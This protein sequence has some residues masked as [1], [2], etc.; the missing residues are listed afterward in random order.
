MSTLLTDLVW[1]WDLSSADATITDQHS[2]L[3]LSRVGTTITES[4]GGPDGGPCINFGA[5]AGKYRNASVAKT[6][7]YDDGFTA[8][9]WV[10]PTGTAFAAN[11][12]L[13]HRVQSGSDRYF[14]MVV[15]QSSLSA[16]R[17]LVTDASQSSRSVDIS[18]QSALN[19]WYMLTLVD[20]GSVLSA[21]RDGVLE[22]TSSTVIGARGTGV[23]DFGIGGSA[24]DATVVSSVNHYGQLAMAGVWNEPLDTA[25]ITALYN[26]GNGRRYADLNI[27][28]GVFPRRRRSRSGGGVL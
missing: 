5:A 14:Q 11:F 4:T 23:A 17:V 8:N 6:V 26:G 27:P 21:Y 28:I 18:P 10:R 16:D 9:I 13:N 7:S 3:S 20:D 25:A 24:W 2:G 1:Y 19:Q 15:R 22:A 12:V